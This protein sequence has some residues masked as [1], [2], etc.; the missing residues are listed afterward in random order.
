[1]ALSGR[2]LRDLRGGGSMRSTM[3][4]FPLTVTSIMRYGTT[5]FGDKEVVTCA[6]DEPTRRRT[7]A[8]GGEPAGAAGERAAPPRRRRR[9]AGRHVH[10]EQRRAPRGLPGHPV[11]GRRAAHAEH[12]AR[13]RPGRLHRHPRGRPRGHRGRLAGPAVR[14]GPAARADR[15]A[16]DR[17]RGA[18]AAQTPGALAELAGASVHS[19]EELLAAEPDSFDWPELDER[20]AAAMCYT[21]GTTGLPK[22]VVYSHRSTYLHS[23]ARLPGQRA[24]P[25]PSATG[26][27]PSCP[28]STPTPG[29]WPTP[30]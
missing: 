4:D 26:C 30:R 24:S 20:S 17:V 22:G 11:H 3:M 9:P 8:D 10:V 13:A 25:S 28:C 12:P 2:Q 16:R 29:A 15:Q 23:M 19:Y 14:R 7:Y 27:C 18:A 5:V 21:S 6:G 1:M